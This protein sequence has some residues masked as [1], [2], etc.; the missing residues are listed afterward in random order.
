MSL[1]SLAPMCGANSPHSEVMVGKIPT[2]SHEIHFPVPSQLGSIGAII[3]M[4]VL[5]LSHAMEIN[6]LHDGNQLVRPGH[7]MGSHRV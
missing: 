1:K 5:F 6:W 7:M 2:T 3:C 4:T